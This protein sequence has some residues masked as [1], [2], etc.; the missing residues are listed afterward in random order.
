MVAGLAVAALMAAAVLVPDSTE[1]VADTTTEKDSA[2][3]PADPQGPNSD[4]EQSTED[5]SSNEVAG[6]DDT[7]SGKDV[8]DQ[9]DERL[10]EMR[11]RF[12]NMFFANLMV[13][14]IIGGGFGISI[15]LS[16]PGK[17]NLRAHHADDADFRPSA[18]GSAGD[19]ASDRLTAGQTEIAG[20][21]ESVYSADPVFDPE[22]EFLQDESTQESVWNPVEELRFAGE[23]F[24]A[25]YL[26][27]VVLKLSLALMMPESPSHPFLELIRDGIDPMMIMGLG[28][29]AVVVAPLTEELLYRVTIFGGFVQQKK[30]ML[31]LVVSSVIFALSHGFPDS[32]ALLPLAFVL[33]YT[34]SRRHSYRT[35]VLVHLLFNLFNMVLAILPML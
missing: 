34:Y 9:A 26:P 2:P 32:I 28:F 8:E 21:G 31:G 20:N 5:G 12:Q 18:D 14:L 23:T 11:T 7:E 15:W 33:A 13:S 4:E 6:N 19:P 24:L 17:R 27:T 3:A 25:A 16:Q 30:F 35:V 22:P 10:A 1:Q 29:M